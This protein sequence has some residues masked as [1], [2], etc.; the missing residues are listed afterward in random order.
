VVCEARVVEESVCS[1]CGQVN[2]EGARFCDGCGAAVESLH[3]ERGL[4]DE[5]RQVTVLFSDASGYT[6]L[7]EHL[8]PE[9]V[10]EVMAT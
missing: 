1:G 6:S 4:R 2:R 5:R 7:V 3:T 8:D 9:V 10:R